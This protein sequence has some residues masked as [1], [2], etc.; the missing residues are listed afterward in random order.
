MDVE[1]EVPHQ[2][3]GTGHRWLDKVLPVSA[4][5]VSFV[6][7]WIAR[8][9]GEVMQNLVRQNER[10][11]QANSLPHFQLQGSSRDETGAPGVSFFVANAGVGPG[12]IRAAR[13]TVDGRPVGNLEEL[14]RA[15]CAGTGVHAGT[16]STLAGV[17]LRPGEKLRYIDVPLAPSTQAWTNALDVARRTDRIV[18][19]VCYCSVFDE[20]W[21]RSSV[22]M[23]RPR[24]VSS[25]AMTGKL[26][27]Q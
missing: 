16:T 19:T 9:H 6:S 4:L 7:I 12:E 25:C 21:T 17:M 23:A 27:R 14:T 3:H 8:H 1:V 20:C 11:V 18:T 24:P 13:I 15:C 10:L 5:F 26:Y 2:H 22:S